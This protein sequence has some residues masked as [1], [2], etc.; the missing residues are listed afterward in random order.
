MKKAHHAVDRDS[1]KDFQQ[2]VNVGPATEGDFRVLG[3]T[4]PQHLINQDPWMLF[5][6]LCQQTETIHDP[7]V[8]DVLMASIDFMNGNPPRKWWDYTEQRKE[9]YGTKLKKFTI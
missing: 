4:K 2:I 3:F 6:K 8:L 9:E 1:I 5:R 7:C